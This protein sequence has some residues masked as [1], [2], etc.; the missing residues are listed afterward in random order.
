M[1]KQGHHG[2]NVVISAR[3]V[4]QRQAVS[5]SL[6]PTLTGQS[7]EQFR[8]AQQLLRLRHPSQ[9]VPLPCPQ[10]AYIACFV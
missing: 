7:L 9:G 1:R 3:I 2:I 8:L 4:K 6:C 5:G 10:R